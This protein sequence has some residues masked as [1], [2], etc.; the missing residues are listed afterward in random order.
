MVNPPQTLFINLYDLALLLVFESLNKLISS[1]PVSNLILR[2]Y[3]EM[4]LVNKTSILFKKLQIN[5]T[6]LEFQNQK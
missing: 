4:I 1:S 2:Y 5:F 6:N 3:I